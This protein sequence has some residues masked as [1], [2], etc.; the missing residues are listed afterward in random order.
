MQV[1]DDRDP[2]S[3]IVACEL[4]GVGGRAQRKAGRHDGQRRK[5]H[6]QPGEHRNQCDR[7]RRRCDGHQWQRGRG[8]RREKGGV[9]ECLRR[10]L[11]RHHDAC[12]GHRYAYESAVHIRDRLVIHYRESTRP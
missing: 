5:T 7:Q 8:P 2:P 10:D 6:E 4:G 1:D 3:G 12:G 9:T 11:V